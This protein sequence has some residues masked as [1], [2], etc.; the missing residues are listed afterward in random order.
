MQPRHTDTEA[1]HNLTVQAVSADGSMVELET[2][3]CSRHWSARSTAYTQFADVADFAARLARLSKGLNGEES[4]VAGR[5]DSPIG[6]LGLRFYSTGR[7]GH[8][9]CHLR[10]ATNEAT[11]HRPEEIWRCS[12]ELAAD[13][14]ALD[15]FIN[16]LQCIAATRRGRAVMPLSI[17]VAH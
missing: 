5:E 10:L 6:F 4:F 3:F 2:S 13:A 11:E 7:T 16:G 15:T 17:Y 14:A 9:V 12:V 1:Q 8:F